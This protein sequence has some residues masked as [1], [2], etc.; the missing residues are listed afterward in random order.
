MIE[1]IVCTEMEMGNEGK[2]VDMGMD[3]E[4]DMSTEMGTG[5]GTMAETETANSKL[6]NK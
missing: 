6:C 4:T 1:R 2:A 3:I 5:M